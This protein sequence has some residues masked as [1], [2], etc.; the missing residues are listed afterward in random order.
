MNNILGI[1]S[2][3]DT[4]NAKSISQF[5]SPFFSLQLLNQFENTGPPPAD[6]DK[7]K[8]LPTVRITDVHVGK[9]EYIIVTT[10]VM[11]VK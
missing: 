8:S 9:L 11:I 6:R 7:I 5:F 2:I 1:L 10:A 3:C 4:Y